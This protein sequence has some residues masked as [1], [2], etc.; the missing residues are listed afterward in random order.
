MR[1]V[2][3]TRWQSHDP[4]FSEELLDGFRNLLADWKEYCGDFLSGP[5]AGFSS[6]VEKAETL[7]KTASR[8]P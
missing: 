6:L 5:D 3:G 7:K 2:I 8:L 4:G 1:A